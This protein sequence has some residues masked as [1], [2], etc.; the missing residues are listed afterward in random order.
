VAKFAK[1][2]LV[3]SFQPTHAT[4]DMPWAEQRIG[5]ARIAFAYAWRS[6]LETGAH[7]AFGSD[8]PVEDPNPLWGLYSART[9]QD[10]SGQPVGGWHSEQT[11][12]GQQALAGFTTGAAYASFAET[13]RGQLAVGFDA[14]FVVLPVDPVEGD[15]KSLIDARVQLTVVDGIDVYRAP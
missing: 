9:R 12:S 2:G 3:A 14:D 15:A 13:R 10:Q 11:L 5:P 6:V 8:F 7:V 4:S 1:L